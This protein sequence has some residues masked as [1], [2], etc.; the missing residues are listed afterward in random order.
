MV[1][2]DRHGHD[3]YRRSYWGYPNY[4][5]GLYGIG[6]FDAGYAGYGSPPITIINNYYGPGQG[7]AQPLQPAAGPERAPMPPPA[8]AEGPHPN[9]VR[10]DIHL[11]AD[12]ELFIQDVKMPQTGSSRRFVSPPVEADRNYTYSVRVVWKDKDREVS[13]TRKLRVR[14]GDHQSVT[15]VAPSETVKAGQ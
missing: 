15:F 6:Y 13:E 5:G 7:P 9:V 11:P 4:Y 2:V 12:A 14:A 1:S 8:A 10:I 3:Y